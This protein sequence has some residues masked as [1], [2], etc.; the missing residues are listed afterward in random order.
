MAEATDNT[1]E[2]TPTDKP[3]RRWPKII[4]PTETGR[5]TIEE[6]DAM[7]A[8][9]ERRRALNGGKGNGKSVDHRKLMSNWIRRV[10]GYE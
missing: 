5:F 6:V 4:T 1:Q 8:E 9:V 7:I 3:K 10:H 2:R